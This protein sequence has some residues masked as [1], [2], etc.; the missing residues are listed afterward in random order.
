MTP[1]DFKQLL[2][3]TTAED[4]VERFIL[5]DDVGPYTSRDA[6][7]VLEQRVGPIGVSH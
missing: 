4:I 2:R 3:E 6:L 1:D 5:T 7:D